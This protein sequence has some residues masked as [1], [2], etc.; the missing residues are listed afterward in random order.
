MTSVAIVLTGGRVWIRWQRLKKLKWDDYL[1]VLAVL[2]LI[3]FMAS[4]FIDLAVELDPT[5]SD[6]DV[7]TSLKI[8]FANQLL[9]WTSLFLVKASFLATYYIV[10][11]VS[12]AFKRAWWLLAVYIGVSYVAI[13]LSVLWDCGAPTS[14]DNPAACA[15]INKH[16]RVRIQIFWVT[17]NVVGDLLLVALPLFML[18]R[19]QMSSVHKWCLAGIF[20]IIVLDMLFDLLRA[21]YSLD[22]LLKKN[23]FANV[24]WAV[25]EPAV[26]VIVCAL[27]SYRSLLRTQPSTRARYYEEP[28]IRAA[29]MGDSSQKPGPQSTETELS[30]MNSRSIRSNV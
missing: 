13:M 30:S 6:E 15:S 20:A 7:I 17:L 28:Q 21:V 16:T 23:L 24:A 8:D 5:A 19:L 9:F 2:F 27:P 14:Y 18:R 1:N 11:S 25:C 29:R 12:K 3:A 4:L 22:S 10:F 26:A